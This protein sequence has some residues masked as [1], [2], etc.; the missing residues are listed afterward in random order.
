MASMLA[1]LV[2]TTFFAYSLVSQGMLGRKN[3][4]VLGFGVFTLG[5][6]LCAFASPSYQGYDLIAY[7]IVQALGGALM[8]SNATPMVADAFKAN[9]LGLGMD[10]AAIMRT[11][12]KSTAMTMYSFRL[13]GSIS[14]QTSPIGI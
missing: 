7:R 2:P 1:G 9:R 12:A 11:A 8:I 4:Y 10:P 5:S 14:S 13:T 3:L 6:L